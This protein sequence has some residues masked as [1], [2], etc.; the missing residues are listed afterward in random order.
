[1]K[2]INLTIPQK[3]LETLYDVIISSG[4]VDI[5][6]E[7]W[8]FENCFVT[9]GETWSDCADY[10]DCLMLLFALNLKVLHYY[11]E[12]SSVTC[13]IAE[14]LWD[15]KEVMN[16]FMEDNNTW[17][18]TPGYY[19]EISPDCDSGFYETYMMTFASL[20]NGNYSERQYEEL[21]KALVSDSDVPVPESE[22]PRPNMKL[23]EVTYCEED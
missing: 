1:M 14:F 17:S 5:C 10:Y 12:Y 6:D 13:N 3:K 7:D 15:H 22:I 4:D 20:I 21:F 9:G 19:K 16:S 8:D 18:H 2:H 23:K 11:P